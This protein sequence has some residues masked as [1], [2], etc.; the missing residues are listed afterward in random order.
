MLVVVSKHS[1]ISVYDYK[2]NVNVYNMFKGSDYTAS[3]VIYAD[4]GIPL[5]V[6]GGLENRSVGNEIKSNQIKLN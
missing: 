5:I 6:V 2:Q 4:N 1:M 3:E